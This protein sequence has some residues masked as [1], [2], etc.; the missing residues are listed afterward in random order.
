MTSANKPQQQPPVNPT[1]VTCEIV[2]EPEKSDLVEEQ[3]FD[4]SG[5]EKLTEELSRT[6]KELELLR[7]EKKE[8]L[9]EK[10]RELQALSSRLFCFSNLQKKSDLNFYTDFPNLATFMALFK[11]LNPDEDCESIRRR[12]KH[13]CGLF[14]RL[15]PCSVKKQRS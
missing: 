5:L 8:R 2:E 4:Q 14:V 1:S 13:C 6:K 7:K 12:G 10:E 15:L 11:F 3:S 9:A